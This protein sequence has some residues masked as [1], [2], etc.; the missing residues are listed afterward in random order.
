ML[1]CRFYGCG[2]VAPEALQGMQILDLGS[3]SGQDCFVLSK[4]VGENGHV[5]GVDMTKEQVCYNLKIAKWP[6]KMLGILVK[7]VIVNGRS[8]LQAVSNIMILQMKHL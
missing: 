1:N 6:P 4:L 3:G 5:T 7:V 2:L 8:H